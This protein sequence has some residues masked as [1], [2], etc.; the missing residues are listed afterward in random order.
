MGE[1]KIEEK[2]TIKKEPEVKETENVIDI[3]KESEIDPLDPLGKKRL[4]EQIQLVEANIEKLQE[5]LQGLKK[6]LE[7]MIQQ[8]T[9]GLEVMKNLE[10]SLGTVSL[11]V[12][13]KLIKVQQLQKK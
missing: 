3:T 2:I 10:T 8:E 12:L 4:E 9:V 6:D 13:L 11:D 5:K 7:K 1:E